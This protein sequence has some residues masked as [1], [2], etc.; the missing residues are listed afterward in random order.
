MSTQ[1]PKKPF[2]S[3]EDPDQP[4]P[5]RTPTRDPIDP[6]VREPGDP[7]KPDIQDPP[8]PGFEDPPAP[9]I[10]RAAGAAPLTAFASVYLGLTGTLIAP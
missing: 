9:V 7:N 3:P 2:E 1:P 6:P 8:V 4:D 5:V 10:N